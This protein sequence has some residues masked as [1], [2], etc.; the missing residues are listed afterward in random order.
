MSDPELIYPKIETG[1]AFT[2]DMRKNFVKKFNN[3]SF[4]QGSAI[5]K[6]NYYNPK[7][8]ILQHL[9]KK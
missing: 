2:K 4:N 8:L 5:L 3:G 1:Y 7:N 6:I 9:P